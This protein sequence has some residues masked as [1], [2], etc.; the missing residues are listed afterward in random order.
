MRF[1]LN[2]DKFPFG[3]NI[4]GLIQSEKGLGA[5]VRADIEALKAA[6][7]PYVINN[8]NDLGSVNIDKTFD[9]ADFSNANPYLFNLIH[10]NPDVFINIANEANKT[11]FEGHYNIGFWVWE[12]DKFPEEWARLANNYLDEIWT[13]SDF[14]FQAISKAILKTAKI[15]VVKIPHCISLS[16][17]EASQDIISK[18]RE[19]IR[20]NLNISPDMFMFLFIFDFQSEIERKNPFAV[21][22]AFKKASLPQDKA[23]LILKTSHSE[24]NKKEFN[25][26]LNEIKGYNITLVDSVYTKEQIYL[27]MNAC[28]C[29]VSLHRSEGFGLTLAEAMALGKPVI[30]TGY[31]G[32]I[33]FINMENSFPVSYR[34]IEIDRDY[35]NNYRKG[36]WWAEPDVEEA[37]EFMRM[38]F[39][40]KAEAKVIGYNGENYIKKFFNAAAVGKIYRLK[41][42]NIMAEIETAQEHGAKLKSVFKE[43]IS[44]GWLSS[45]NTKCGIAT[46]SRYLSENF[47]K[48]K[49]EI[50]YFANKVSYNLL[51]E[52][53][54]SN[55]CRLWNN[56]TDLNLDEVLLE[57]I[58]KKIDLVIVQFHPSFFNIVELADFINKVKNNG[59]KIIID[60]HVV[61]DLPVE[62][63]L[64]SSLQLI[65][66]A[67][68]KAD[69]L[70][71]HNSGDVEILKKSGLESNT[72]LFPPGL[73]KVVF[74]ENST[75]DLMV[76]MHFK[77]KFVISTFGFLMPHK[78]VLELISAFAEL[79]KEHENIHLLL[80][81]AVRPD[82]SVFEEYR[83]ECISKIT[84][85]KLSSD[86]TFI[87]DFLPDEEVLR[88]LSMSD[89]VVY[90]YQ[91][92]KES[93]SGAVRYGLSAGRTVL[94]TPL[95]IFDE[96]KDI[97][98]FLTGTDI[99]SIYAGIKFFIEKPDELYR[100][101]ILQQKWVEEHAWEKLSKKLQEIAEEIV[102]LDNKIK[103]R[104]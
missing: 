11:Y 36:N 78:G 39:E 19:A 29:Y 77:D 42:N 69:A 9:S 1:N 60:L 70:L 64:K 27:L 25:R 67:L 45:W 34:L 102:V 58:S 66:E 68:K 65:T 33:D 98:S 94:C 44:I 82:N 79:K 81:N 50:Y 23:M 22:D 71:A 92:T 73:K 97:A 61:E 38:I 88:L 53:D 47:D 56:S 51:I 100:S 80:I 72:V 90:P 35:G 95:K 16:S 14:S 6:G 104:F 4:S 41:L 54:P 96:V 20:R 75:E 21:I 37:A 28:D 85:L 93:A 24:F 3:V 48:E 13:P 10:V 63:G 12:L 30:A 8:I 26:L 84:E 91:N 101:K 17:P 18:E 74:N 86:V 52:K 43:K 5:A 7:I 2:F 99:N 31:S 83:K 32:N 55:V 59:I 103:A 89:L 76:N 49:F 57:L 40:D 15:P 62:S 87:T 46:H